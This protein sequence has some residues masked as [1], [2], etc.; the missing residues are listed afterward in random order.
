MVHCQGVRTADQQAVGYRNGERPRFGLA[1]ATARCRRHW[2]A[3]SVNKKA[4]RGHA[5]VKAVRGC[6]ILYPL[7]PK[8]NAL[9]FFHNIA[10]TMCTTPPTNAFILHAHRMVAP[11]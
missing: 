10:L 1:R 2:R 5:D 9:G 8:A 4:G 11:P 7:H 6:G 3:T